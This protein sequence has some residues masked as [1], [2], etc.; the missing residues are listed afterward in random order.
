MHP[1]RFRSYLDILLAGLLKPICI[2]VSFELLARTLFIILFLSPRRT[3]R[4]P[5]ENGGQRDPRYRWSEFAL[6]CVVLTLLCASFTTAWTTFWTLRLT[7][8]SK[9]GMPTLA[10]AIVVTIQFL[11]WAA[12]MMVTVKRTPREPEGDIHL[13]TFLRFYV[14]EGGLDMGELQ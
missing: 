7:H 10:F 11:L 8:Q 3:E 13:Q 9:M 14:S 2:A 5:E 6:N 1:L 4:A 12:S